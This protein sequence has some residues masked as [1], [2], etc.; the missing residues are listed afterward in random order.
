M[1][2]PGYWEPWLLGCWVIGMPHYWGAGLLGYLILGHPIIG[3]PTLQGSSA[4]GR[5]GCSPSGNHG[6]GTEQAAASRGAAG[7]RPP[8][9][10]SRGGSAVP[11]APSALSLVTR[12]VLTPGPPPRP[13][14]GCSTSSRAER[15]AARLPRQVSPDKKINH[16]SQVG[17]TPKNVAR[18]VHERKN[19]RVRFPGRAGKLPQST[20]DPEPNRPQLCRALG[21]APRR[22]GGVGVAGK[23][24]QSAPGAFS[25]RMHR[26]RQPH[27]GLAAMRVGTGLCTAACAG[28]KAEGNCKGLG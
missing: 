8:Q 11:N 12:G 16:L 17:Q 20:K 18:E 5:R 14:P 21:R 4:P 3:V 2:L 19:E 24:G 28:L 13:P 15:G 10:L 1:G 27:R 23:I 26:G 22:G 25:R 9:R 7:T 6:P